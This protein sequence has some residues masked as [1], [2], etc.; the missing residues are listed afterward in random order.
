VPLVSIDQALALLPGALGIAI[1]SFADT[2]L[3]G[4]SFAARH[5][6][7]TE[8]DREL[9]ALAAADLGSSL[10]SGY[11]IGSS[12]SRTAAGEAAGSRTQ[13]TSVVAALAVAFVLLF[14]TGP[15]AQLPMPALG[16]VILAS[17]LRFI[18]V[19][20]IVRIWN[21]E[22][23]EGAIAV[24]AVL[25]VILYG[26]LA[27]V[28]IAVVLAALNVFRRAASPR[29]DELGRL[30]DGATFASLN[31]NPQ[32]E[33]VQGLVVVRFAGPL[34]FA[35]ATALLKAVRA[36]IAARTDPRV[37]V[38]DASAIVD[39]DLTAADALRQLD[40]ELRV[41]GIEFIIAR[42]AGALRD[43]MRNLGLGALVGDESDVR[44]TIVAAIGSR[45]AARPAETVEDLSTN[46]E[47]ARAPLHEPSGLSA[48]PAA[49]GQRRRNRLH[50]GLLIVGAVAIASVIGLAVFGGEFGG[51]S[52]PPRDSVAVPNL[53]GLPLER[54]RTA[55][56]SAG[57]VLGEPTVVESTAVAEGTV[58][59][60]TPAAGTIV[61]SGSEVRPVVSTARGLVAVPDVAGM[62]EA[63][64]VVELTGAG[65]RIGETVRDPS[66]V[67]PDGVV[68]GTVPPPGRDVAAGSAVTLVVS[69][70]EPGSSTTPRPTSSPSPATA[71]SPSP[72]PSGSV[73]ASPSDG[74]SPPATTSPSAEPSP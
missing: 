70:G 73:G 45:H 63:E 34:F 27:G 26:T 3:T 13:M 15:M 48:T 52:A 69:T 43:L 19:G 7:E 50:A 64:A 56:E 22:R 11:P 14:L 8:P 18:N 47:A 65:L 23:T 61:A 38:L 4:R 49:A 74:S 21:L 20:G 29:I 55:T 10:T 32:A 71:P 2:A 41:S 36:L 57:L 37:V 62:A 17:V 68:I 54:A 1:L 53:V 67:V 72:E 58:V 25:G 46:P 24:I 9:V 6:E 30:P 39:L 59:L 5:G 60:Q 66:S 12:P 51:A 35:T 28:G 31:R 16:A 44:R 40:E 33:R 42:P